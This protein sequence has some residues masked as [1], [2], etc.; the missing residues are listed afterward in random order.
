MKRKTDTDSMKTLTAVHKILKVYDDNLDA[1]ALDTE[2]LNAK[3]LKLSENR[4]TKIIILLSKS[5]Y[6]ENV[7]IREH[8]DG[9]TDVDYS[10]SYITLAGLKYYAENSLFLRAAGILPDLINAGISTV[11]GIL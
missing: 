4:F 6:I 8:Q 7:D 11:T 3:A 1:D 5:G 10:E 9:S 2:A